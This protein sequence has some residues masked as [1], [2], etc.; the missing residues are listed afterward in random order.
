VLTLVTLM[1]SI[2]AEDLI[3]I[4]L[5][6]VSPKVESLMARPLTVTLST[7]DADT[8]DANMLDPSIERFAIVNDLQELASS[9]TLVL[10]KLV[11]VLLSKETSR[12]FP[13]NEKSTFSEYPLN[14][15]PL[16]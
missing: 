8:R 15:L 6:R 13:E 16:I 4:N 1:S 3:F 2:T 5:I 11:K 7:D 9:T 10:D 14:R 12:L